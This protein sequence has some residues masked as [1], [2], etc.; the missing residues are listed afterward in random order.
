ML[1]E[2]IICACC[3]DHTKS[4]NTRRKLEIFK[5]KIVPIDKSSLIQG[6]SYV[7][8]GFPTSAVQ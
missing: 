3:Y 1:I 5:K 6:N 4:K 8:P 7:P 2:L